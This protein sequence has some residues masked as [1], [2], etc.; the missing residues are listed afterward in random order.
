MWGGGGVSANLPSLVQARLQASVCPFGLQ[1]GTFSRGAW[2]A[3]SG[4]LRLVETGLWNAATFF[5]AA[6][7]E[8]AS[9]RGVAEA[10]ESESQMLR[11]GGGA[12][13]ERFAPRC[14]LDVVSIAMTSGSCSNVCGGKPANRFKLNRFTND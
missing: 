13:N 10:E 1:R 6:V 9:A 14:R 12:G 8:T 3:R 7:G 5:A 2:H 4:R 11:M